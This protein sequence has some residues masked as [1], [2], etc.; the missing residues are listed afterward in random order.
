MTREWKMALLAGLGGA[1]LSLIV[2]LG[3]AYAGLLPER[4]RDA[5]FHD[6]LMSHASILADMSVKMQTEQQASEEAARQAAVDKLG[7]ASFFD[8]RVAF[9]TGPADAKTTMVEFFDYNCPYC[10]ASL[11]TVKKFYS[12]NKDKA[13]FAFIDFPIKGPNSVIAARAAVAARKQPAK[14]LLFHFLLM[15][16]EEL[17]T[18]DT[19]FTDARK[20]GLDV[21]KLKTDMMDKSVDADIAAAKR[22]ADAAKVDG[23]PAFIIDGN[24]REGA[25]SDD[26]LASFAKKS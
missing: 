16:E 7:M 15:E 14:Y 25:L 18:A 10:R 8:P 4:N 23:T 1:A 9:V 24:M 19:V 5:Q 20:A 17:V 26:V 3:L 12:A 11:P 21:N 6:Y 13:R 2:V 22:L